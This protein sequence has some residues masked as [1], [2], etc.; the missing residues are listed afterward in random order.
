MTMKSAVIVTT[1][2]DPGKLALVLEGLIRQSVM[3]D[4]IL[5]ADDGSGPE[6]RDLVEGHQPRMPC[7]LHHVWHEDRGFGKMAI[8]NA[9]VRRSAADRYIFLDGDSIPHRD[10][11]ADHV[12]SHGRA[13]VLCGRRVKIGPRLTAKVDRDM[14]RRGDLER[15]FG[16]V[17]RSALGGDTQRFALGVR[18]P[19]V[20]ANVFHP[21]PRKLMGVNFSVTRLAFHGVNGYDRDA[22]AKREDR[23]LELRLLRGG[24]SF[25]PLLNRAIVYHLHHPFKPASPEDERYLLEHERS[26]RV[27]CVHGLE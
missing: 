19:Q 12:A 2:N 22:P 9:A 10:W 26:G 7:P 21:R 8:C 18:M 16:P 13:D 23:E 27:R 24:Y 14:V 4:E 6:T 15:I 17:F 11:V 25:A 1:Y 3:P 5:I 20:L